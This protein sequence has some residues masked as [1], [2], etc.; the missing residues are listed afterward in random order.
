MATS[1]GARWKGSPL[2]L[3]GSG[4]LG[5]RGHGP[6]SRGYKERIKRHTLGAVTWLP[7]PTALVRRARLS[8]TPT[9]RPKSLRAAAQ[10]VPAG[11]GP[12]L[13]ASEKRSDC[14]RRATTLP[15]TPTISWLPAWA[16]ETALLPG[17]GDAL[18]L[19]RRPRRPW[20][21]R[22][23][24]LVRGM[25]KAEITLWASSFRELHK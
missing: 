5:G 24:R 13:Q 22:F 15:A 1:S 14:C 25:L 11:L 9:A 8:G 4:D 3:G 19:G 16:A 6:A 7:F 20:G 2:C 12:Q 21:W 17:P 10:H 18:V 23:Q